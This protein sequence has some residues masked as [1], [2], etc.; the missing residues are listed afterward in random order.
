MSW[1]G[2][3]SRTGLYQTL[4]NYTKPLLGG[5]K[6]IDILYVQT[7]ISTSYLGPSVTPRLGGTGRVHMPSLS[8]FSGCTCSELASSAL[9]S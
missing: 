9:L 3:V 4:I 8:R 2:L 6:D 5:G 7:F 1:W